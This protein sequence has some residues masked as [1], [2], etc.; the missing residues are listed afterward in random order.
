MTPVKQLK[1]A[2]TLIE[3]L[4]VVAI[5]AILAAI[6]VPNFLEAQTRAKVSRVK[7]DVRALVTATETYLVDYGRYPLPSDEDGNF[8]SNPAAGDEWYETKTAI[9]LT[10]PIAYMTSRVGDVFAPKTSAGIQNFHY[11]SLTYID[12][13]GH[14]REEFY[15]YFDHLKGEGFASQLQYYY[16]SYGPDTDHDFEA[17]DHEGHEHGEEG[18]AIYDATNGTISSGDLYYVG[19]GTGFL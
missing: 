4:I 17:G 6:A 13:G 8:M 1:T 14:P 5:I 18:G 7:S 16:L 15:E 9:S 19:P 2:F 3:L 12:A 10:T 11:T